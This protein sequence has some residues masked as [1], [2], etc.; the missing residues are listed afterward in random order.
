MTGP[1]PFAPGDRVFLADH[2][3]RGSLRVSTVENFWCVTALGIREDG[4]AGWKVVAPA[5]HFRLA[6]PDWAEPPPPPFASACA[7]ADALA[8]S[9]WREKLA[10]WLG[11]EAGHAP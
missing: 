5:D 9:L 2:P 7:C 1:A 3:R 8:M 6:P 10:A 4:R 11:A